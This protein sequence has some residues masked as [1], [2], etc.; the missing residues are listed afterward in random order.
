MD[1]FNQLLA[2]LPPDEFKLLCRNHGV[3][4]WM[5]ADEDSDINESKI[6]VEIL[7]RNKPPPYKLSEDVATCK[8]RQ[9]NAKQE[10]MCKELASTN[11]QHFKMAAVKPLKE[12]TKKSKKQEVKQPK[13]TNTKQINS[14]ITQEFPLTLINFPFCNKT[15]P[16]QNPVSKIPHHHL[17]HNGNG[18]LQKENCTSPLHQQWSPEHIA[19]INKFLKTQQVINPKK[20]KIC[21][22]KESSTDANNIMHSIKNLRITDNAASKLTESVFK[23]PKKTKKRKHIVDNPEILAG[24]NSFSRLVPTSNSDASESEKEPD[25]DTTPA[26]VIVPKSKRK[27]LNRQKKKQ[28]LKK[29]KANSARKQIDLQETEDRFMLQGEPYMRENVADVINAPPC[30]VERRFRIIHPRRGI[31]CWPRI[32]IFKDQ[33]TEM[34]DQ[35]PSR[36]HHVFEWMMRHLQQF[37]H[38][39]PLLTRI[40]VNIFKYIPDFNGAH[41]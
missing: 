16:Q 15:Q 37:V 7:E 22:T 28:Q 30:L 21:V 4:S 13:Q 39:D 8:L 5:S 40:Q 36:H 17:Q 12:K 25:E 32:E 1:P 29:S 10:E 24:G 3:N 14:A 31:L 26:R 34:P 27:R 20:P 41:H 19:N 35:A 18:L 2:A 9:Y 33:Y 6:T 23:K 11:G 38:I